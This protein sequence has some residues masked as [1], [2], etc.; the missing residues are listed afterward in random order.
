MIT[1]ADVTKLKKTFATKDDLKAY[2]TNDDLKKT[3]KSLTDLITE[4]KDEIL[5]EIKGMREEI[6]IVIG[7]KDQIEDIDYR[8]ERLEKFT[9]IPPVA[10]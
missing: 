5:H 2:A 9:K 4:F 10:P 1:D 3:Q 6:A 7:Y 8:V